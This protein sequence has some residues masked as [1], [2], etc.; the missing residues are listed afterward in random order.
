MRRRYDITIEQQK[1][2]R[3][4]IDCWIDE[5]ARYTQFMRTIAIVDEAVAS[6]SELFERLPEVV[7]IRSG[8]GC[9]SIEAVQALW[10]MLVESGADRQTVLVVVGGGALCDSVNFAAST[11]MRGIGV[12]LLPTTLLAQVD[13]AIGGKC[14]VNVGGYKNMVGTFNLPSAVV[15]DTSWLKTLP[16]REWR[17]GM[18]EVIKTA[19]VGDA[20]LFEMLEGAT[21]E[22]LQQDKELLDAVV[23]RCV[24]VK[25]DIVSQDPYDKG[26]RKRLNLGHTI[27]HAIESLTDRYAHGEAVAIG[28][29]WVSRRA[30]ERGLLPE[31]VCQRVVALLRRYGLPTELPEGLS[32]ESI[33]AAAEHDK[34]SVDGRVRWVVPRALGSVEELYW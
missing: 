5:V 12:V 29:A 19:V 4:S 34:K 31:E 18:A 27:G 26:V 1:S 15:C 13:A 20:E 14:G 2:S 22:Q 28:L 30:V 21:L 23:G 8:E 32:E 10:E 7:T 11:F 9:K 16:E 33:L 25:C 3:V 6:E 17:S 24:A